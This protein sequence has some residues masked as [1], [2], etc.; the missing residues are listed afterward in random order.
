MDYTVHGILPARILGWV[1]FP[2]SR[3][4]AQPRNWAQ[5]FCIAGR[6]FISWATREML[7]ATLIEILIIY[8][9][10]LN[11]VLIDKYMIQLIDVSKHF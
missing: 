7:I 11:F 8:Q 6:F 1:A 3:A 4:P 10:N 2:F 9:L 5:V